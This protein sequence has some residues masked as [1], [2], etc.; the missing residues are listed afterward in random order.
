MR[1]AALCMCNPVAMGGF[2][3]L[4]SPNKVLIPPNWSVK[5]YKLG[6][7]CQFLNVKPPCTNVKTPIED[8]L[9]TVLCIW[10]R[11]NLRKWFVTTVL[12]LPTH[13]LQPD[14]LFVVIQK[15]FFRVFQRFAQ[16]VKYFY[17]KNTW[18]NSKIV[19]NKWKWFKTWNNFG[20]DFV[21]KE[22][23]LPISLEK[24]FSFIAAYKVAFDCYW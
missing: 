12:T 14:R 5:H 21:R 17:Q 10:L 11:N 23:K 7:F 24:F 6:E 19:L 3:G 15:Q 4:S 13:V 1:S 20:K 18:N 9:V 2:G 16:E 22:S 8:F